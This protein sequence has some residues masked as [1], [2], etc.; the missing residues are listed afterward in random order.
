MS[1]A[2]S[3]CKSNKFGQN[4]S[5]NTDDKEIQSLMVTNTFLDAK[6]KLFQGD[7]QNATITFNKCIEMQPNHDASY[8]ELAR[9]NEF[10]NPTI[11]IEYIKK[12]IEYSPNNNWYKELLIRIYKQQK[13]F[14]EAISIN[15]ELIKQNINS[16]EYYYQWA[17]LC[18]DAKDY[19]QAIKAY[20][21]LIDKFSYEEGVLKQQKQIYLKKGDYKNAIVV[22]EKL[23]KHNP[24]NKNYYGMIAEIY[25]NSNKPAR[26]MEYY[27]R[28]LEID[29]KDGFVHFS[30][31]DFYYKNGNKEKTLEELKKG[32][33]AENLEIDAKVKVLVK[34]MGLVEKDSTYRNSFN[35]LLDIALEVNYNSP[36]IMAIKAD[37][38]NNTNDTKC[39]IKY[40]RKVIAL[41]S[42]KYII[43]EQLL[44]AEKEV[45]DYNALLDE[46]NRA[47][48]IFPQQAKLYY[49]SAIA[50]GYNNNWKKAEERVHMGGNFIYQSIDKASFLALE[51]KAQFRQ[52]EYDNAKANYQRA[53]KLDNNNALLIKDYAFDIASF[54]TD[55]PAA[56]LYAKE[57]LEKESNNPEYIYVY[58]YCLFKDNQKEEALRWLNP[59]LEKYPKNKSL[60]LLDMEI[61]KNE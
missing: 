15:N 17:N 25:M 33:S 50:Y 55:Y 46:S 6:R 49:Y 52:G 39:A 3:S 4:T 29:P 38:C 37:Y 59:A 41:D 13:N 45:E 22:L 36:K 7:V 19:N 61:K 56:L 23:I 8:F 60:Q 10:Q 57:A 20:Q 1:L 26:A 30:I 43:W 2:L 12:A 11:A 9:I 35:E 53:M 16:K 24:T 54:T 44:I 28:I 40:L 32:M 48:R 27:N 31:A 58:A 18:I 21:D 14:T 51:A 42:T 5:K 47:L 34:M